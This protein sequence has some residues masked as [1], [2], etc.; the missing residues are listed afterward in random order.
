MG[1]SRTISVFMTLP[2][3]FILSSDEEAKDN[4]EIIV[5]GIL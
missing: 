5:Q 2:V 1:E 4:H 3:S